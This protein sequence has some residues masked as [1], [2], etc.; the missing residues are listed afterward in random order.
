MA[1]L[2]RES[3]WL[4]R[5]IALSLLILFAPSIVWLWERWTMSVWHNAH[6]LIIAILI[7]YIISKKLHEARDLPTSDSAWGFLLLV[8]ALLLHALDAGMHTQIVSAAAMY[9]ALP[10]LS[11]LFLG[12]QRTKAIII[13]LAFLI[14]T[15]P[16]PL[17]LT[18]TI[19]LA[20]RHIAANASAYFMP[21]IGIPVYLENTILYTP[22]GALMVADACSGFSTLYASLVFA[23]LVAYMGHDTT[24]RVLVILAAVP[25]AI[26][27]NIIRVILLVV[28]VDWQGL[29]AL[30]TPIHT[31]SGLFTFAL[32]IPLLLWI[33][34]SPVRPDTPQ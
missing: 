29:S 30:N 24:R 31:I 15:L 6:G 19:H 10:G 27:A 17:M 3:K 22:N 32:A 21:V 7:I 25:V 26:I 18:E 14:F 13:P 34:H 12:T 11:L 23:C 28:L 1:Y 9:F 4:M 20:L 2:I 5:L 8:P 33:G 16:I